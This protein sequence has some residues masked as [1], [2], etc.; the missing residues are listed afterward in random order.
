MGVQ[1]EI[2]RLKA[3]PAISNLMKGYL[4]EPK[5]GHHSVIIVSIYF[6]SGRSQL[7]CKRVCIHIYSMTTTHSVVKDFV[8]HSTLTQNVHNLVALKET[9]SVAPSS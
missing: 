4:V 5:W 6:K 9:K 7:Q 8:G 3:N 2:K 1:Q